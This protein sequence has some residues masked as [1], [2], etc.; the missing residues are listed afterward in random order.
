MVSEALICIKHGKELFER[1]Q[2]INI[3]LWLV[4]QLII[5]IFCVIGCVM[6]HKYGLTRENSRDLSPVKST[7]VS[8]VFFENSDGYKED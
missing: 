8:K 7:N 4:V 5:S 1:T 2:A 6:W 3:I